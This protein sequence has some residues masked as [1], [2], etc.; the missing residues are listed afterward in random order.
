MSEKRKR[1]QPQQPPAKHHDDIE[2]GE[3][4]QKHPTVVDTLRP[5]KPP[6]KRDDQRKK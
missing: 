4:D 5:P 6:P 1:P 2:F 3:G